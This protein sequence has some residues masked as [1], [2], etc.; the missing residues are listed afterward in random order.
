MHRDGAID[1]STSPDCV[2]KKRTKLAAD[3]KPPT[4]G[5]VA[6]TLAFVGST[7]SEMNASNEGIG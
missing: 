6:I 3:L 4:C 7:V 2:Q 5:K 1:I